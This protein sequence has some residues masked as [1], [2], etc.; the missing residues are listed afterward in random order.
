M[1]F[2]RASDYFGVEW[3]VRWDMVG[4]GD[5]LLEGARASGIVN[6]YMPSAV[7][8]NASYSTE[9]LGSRAASRLAEDAG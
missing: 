8:A 2:L 9:Q 4:E 6:A 1:G 3:C 5:E 7:V